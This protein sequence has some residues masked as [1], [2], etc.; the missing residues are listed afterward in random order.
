[1]RG[2]ERTARVRAVLEAERFDAVLCALPSNVLMLSGYWPAIGGSIAI[3]TRD[4]QVSLLVPEDEAELARA[5]WARHV[6]TY[7]P[8]SLQDLR[9]IEQRI[10]TPLRGVIARLGLSRGVIG[11]E[12]GVT[13]EPAAFAARYRFGV[14][15]ETLL[16]FR[17]LTAKLVNA[18]SALG[19]LRA[20]K[21]DDELEAIRMAAMVTTTAFGEG[22]ARLRVGMTEAEAAAR[23]RMPLSVVGSQRTGVARA[24]GFVLCSSGPN[25]GLGPRSFAQAGERRLSHGDAVTIASNAYADGYWVSATR[26]YLLGDVDARVRGWLELVLEARAA[27]VEAVRV[28]ALAADVDRAARNVLARHGFSLGRGLGHEVGFG[29]MDDHAKP[30]IHPLS[31]DVLEPGM[32]F[33]IELAISGSGEAGVRHADVVLVTPTGCDVLTGFQSDIESLT[34]VRDSMVPSQA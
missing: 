28:G 3:A 7:D 19:D 4:G 32:V 16:D 14:L 33:T 26:T 30:R 31:P 13:L 24:D 20:Q 8:A 34:L 25:A 23:F 21:T 18:T 1:M 27:A 2:A 10:I 15:L 5:S 17:I 22:A 9:P 6:D 12:R 11:W 29:V